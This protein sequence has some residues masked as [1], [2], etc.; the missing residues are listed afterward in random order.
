MIFLVI[1][2]LSIMMMIMIMIMM[3][4]DNDDRL[5][6]FKLDHASVRIFEGVDY[7]EKKKEREMELRNLM[8]TEVTSQH[9]RRRKVSRMRVR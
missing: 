3:M 8:F 6:N 2:C 7:T 4:D 1:N 9:A 5:L